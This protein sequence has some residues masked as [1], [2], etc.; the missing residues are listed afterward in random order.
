[1]E[2]A[3]ACRVSSLSPSTFPQLQNGDSQLLVVA[4]SQFTSTGQCGGVA[5]FLLQ[6]EQEVPCW[7]ER[8]L[9]CTPGV[10]CRVV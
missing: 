1:M 4:L 8:A 6:P 5:S 3:L 10:S 2:H 7:V 9:P